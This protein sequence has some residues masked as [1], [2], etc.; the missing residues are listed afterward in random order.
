MLLTAE[1]AW[2]HAME[3]KSARGAESGHQVSG[4]TRRQISSRIRR[5]RDC[6]AH[7]VELLRD[8]GSNANSESVLQAHVYHLTLAGSFAFQQGQWLECVRHYSG[9]RYVYDYLASSNALGEGD[10]FRDII[11]SD[12]DQGLRYAAHQIGI[13][14]ATS[15]NDIVI[16][17]LPQQDDE[18]IA[19][20]H[21]RDHNTVCESPTASNEPSVPY[22]EM[23][24]S[25]VWRHRA[26][27]IEHAGIANAL[28]VVSSAEA[29]LTEFFLNLSTANVLEKAAAYDK[30]LIASQ[31][32]VDASKNAIEELT[33]DGIPQADHRMQ[34]LQ[35]SRTALHYKL[36]GWRV[37][38][39]RI[40]CGNADGLNLDALHDHAENRSKQK[41][42]L[43][44]KERAV[45]YEAILQSLESVKSLPGVASDE[46]FWREIEAKTAYFRSLR[47]L[48]IARCYSQLS[49][50]LEALGLVLR[51]QNYVSTCTKQAHG[52][53]I[54]IDSGPP[55]P[56]IAE[57]KIRQLQQTLLE[58]SKTLRGKVAL[59]DTHF[60]KSSASGDTE[61]AFIRHLDV[62]PARD[63]DLDKLINLYP[64]LQPIPVK[65]IFLDLAYNYLQYPGQAETSSNTMLTSETLAQQQESMENKKSWFG[66]RR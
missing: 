15:I 22:K 47:C 25:I 59:Q 4:S 19:R 61:Q 5:A 6:A 65:P 28:A 50:S 32:A 38:R 53:P 60:I 49:R 12:V 31:D 35:V 30:V 46:S 52:R 43:L 62:F 37:G 16:R 66:F 7:L 36:V 56:D 8:K 9:A 10:L 44:L 45:L 21:H 51:A 20:V 63:I 1:R 58:M 42:I 11:I 3:M 54:S 24:K 40:L 23:R 17:H 14:R 18:L 29:G 2:S 39:N 57:A 34:T 13:P 33:A 55:G 26:V 41:V 27:N 64:R 48:A